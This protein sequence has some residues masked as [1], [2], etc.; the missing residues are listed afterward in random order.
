MQKLTID[1]WIGMVGT[2]ANL[3]DLP[4]RKAGLPYAVLNR[5]Q[6]G[7]LFS[8]LCEAQAIYSPAPLRD[9]PS[10]SFPHFVEIVSPST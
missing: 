1:I 2:K 5:D 8:L 10:L 3:S 4:A 9:A 7:R 6:L